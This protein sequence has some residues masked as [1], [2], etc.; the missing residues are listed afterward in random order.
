MLVLSIV[1]KRILFLT[2]G[3]MQ[4][5]EARRKNFNDGFAVK[6]RLS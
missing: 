3:N 6:I 5:L 2:K 1:F 4:M